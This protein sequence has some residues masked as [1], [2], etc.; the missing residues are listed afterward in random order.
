MRNYSSILLLVFV[1]ISCSEKKEIPKDLIP[2]DKMALIITDLE[3]LESTYNLRL[4][5]VTDRDER[6]DRYNA[7][8]MSHYG[9]TAQQ[10]ETSYNYYE[11]DPVY[12]EAIYEK[13]FERL[14]KMQTE[15]ETKHP[16]EKKT[17]S[18]AD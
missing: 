18:K 15:E 5:R 2:E 6:M 4:I 9:I 11:K 14:E 12:L 3:L 8:I 1:L 7:E 17:K 13:V 10:F 16:P